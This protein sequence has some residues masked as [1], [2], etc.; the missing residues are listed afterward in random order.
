MLK[1]IFHKCIYPL[2]HYND[3][4]PSNMVKT[5]QKKFLLGVSLI[6]VIDLSEF[7][8]YLKMTYFFKSP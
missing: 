5:H 4:D 7:Y 3:E 8:K 2:P 1:K 6:F